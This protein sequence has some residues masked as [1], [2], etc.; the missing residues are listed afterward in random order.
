MELITFNRAAHI[1]GLTEL[2]ITFL[3]ERNELVAYRSQ[4]ECYVTKDDVLKYYKTHRTHLQN[5]FEAKCSDL[6]AIERLVLL[7]TK[8]RVRKKK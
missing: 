5:Y 1:L 3:V 4:T 8:R 2:A 7:L 6:P